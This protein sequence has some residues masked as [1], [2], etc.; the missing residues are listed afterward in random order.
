MADR[1]LNLKLTADTKGVTDAVTGTTS[2]LKGAF[3]EFSHSV[4]EGLGLGAGIGVFGLVTQGVEE[5][6]NVIGDAIGAAREAQVENA[7]LD[8]SLQANVKGWDGNTQAIEG[9]I[10]AREALGFTDNQQ[11]DALALL[12]VHTHDVTTALD[13][14]RVAMDLARLKGMDLATA[15]VLVGKAY[16]GNITSLK[17]LGI[18]LPK[19]IKGT[20]ALA[21][22][23]KVAANQADVFSHTAEGASQAV[24][25]ELEGA[26]EKL[27][28]AL[29]PVETALMQMAAAVIPAV[30]TVVDDL[31]GAWQSLMDLLDPAGA[32]IR[33]ADDDLRTQT[34]GLGL[35]G[36][37]LE[38]YKKSIEDVAAAQAKAT[39]IE[40]MH[41]TFLKQHVGVDMDA[42]AAEKQ[43]QDNL[44]GA[45]DAL[46]QQTDTLDANAAAHAANT[47]LIAD[48]Q[49]AQAQEESQSRR[50]AEATDLAAAA[51]DKLTTALGGN[52]LT[53]YDRATGRLREVAGALAGMS[54]GIPGYDIA[55]SDAARLTS[56]SVGTITELVAALPTDIR[57]GLEDGKS[58]VKQ[59]MKDLIFEMNHPF[60]EERHQAYLMGV[61]TGKRLRE[62][63]HST[64]P[65]VL[66]GARSTRDA[67]IAGLSALPDKAN[68][69][70]YHAGLALIEGLKTSGVLDK[71][72][73]LFGL[74]GASV[75]ERVY[76]QT[77]H[78]ASGGPVGGSAGAD[79][80]VG[81]RGPE[82]LHIGA[83]SGYITPN[84]GG[85][86]TYN[87]NVVAPASDPAGVGRSIVAAI[88]AY[89]RREG[90]NWRTA[91]GY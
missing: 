14:E 53:A 37:A 22:I 15:S 18:E 59:G 45:T 82:M 54:E 52:H 13:A 28:A 63:L 71:V 79:F 87:I 43:W 44:S 83:G 70:G 68:E 31:S 21:A 76:R 5:V 91:G 57:K 6:V 39:Q 84:G 11:K 1:T 69:V 3:G 23:Q 35:S 33:K 40:Q 78:R 62:G 75:S 20:A 86:R 19:G 42:A 65:I 85:G 26:M 66:A 72:A 67:A 58:A 48:Y 7:K 4:K 60:L 24:G 41:Q 73:A 80:L 89:E 36:D 16:D 88:K 12:V 46:F 17:K 47:K 30:I 32:A 51:H 77:H 50:N 49:A 61:L 2:K 9:T 90:K 55:W 34:A 64:N 29:I 81:E 8:A 27:G 25:A 74:G 56:V 10:K 38:A